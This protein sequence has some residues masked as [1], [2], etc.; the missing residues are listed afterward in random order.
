MNIPSTLNI[1]KEHLIEF[2]N[3]ELRLYNVPFV[4]S[5][6][7][8]TKGVWNIYDS[9]D[10]RTINPNW[11]PSFPGNKP[12]EGFESHVILEYIE[13]KETFGCKKIWFI[14]RVRG[15]YPG[16]PYFEELNNQFKWDSLSITYKELIKLIEDI[17]K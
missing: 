16:R 17:K 12:Y 8:G 3:D 14:L 7:E 15:Y 4:F 10:V 1:K 11:T 6:E 13:D 9:Y 2:I 5:D